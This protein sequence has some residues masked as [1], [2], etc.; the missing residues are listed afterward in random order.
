MFWAKKAAALPEVPPRVIYDRQVTLKRV[1]RDLPDPLLAALISG[2]ELHGDN[3][4]CGT[5]FP[6]HSTS[7]VAGAMVRE[8]Y[9]E[10]FACGRIKFLVRHQWRRRAASYGGTLAKCSHV[11]HLEA[12]FDRAV[13]L[14]V[15]LERK[16]GVKEDVAASAAGRW[17]RREAERELGRRHDIAAGI[18]VEPDPIPEIKP[19]EPKSMRQRAEVVG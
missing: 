13:M 15:I 19:I 5:L 17:I 1:L 3:M 6:S 9:P 4:G 7:C 11:S 16:R 18:E 10:E 12:I 14:T 2:L 8:L